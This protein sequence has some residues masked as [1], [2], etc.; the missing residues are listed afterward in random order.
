MSEIPKDLAEAMSWDFSKVRDLIIDLNLNRDEALKDIC[1]FLR[2]KY[3]KEDKGI[4]VGR[5][6]AAPLS[7][8]ML[9]FNDK[10]GHA[11]VR[12]RTNIRR[13]F[14]EDND[15]VP[16]SLKLKDD[17]VTKII[18]RVRPFPSK[19]TPLRPCSGHSEK[20][21]TLVCMALLTMI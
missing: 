6:I 12:L 19:Y 15:G 20:F 18:I 10:E 21:R 4:V 16:I 7:K 13:G 1:D 11:F 5:E 3:M 2:Q 17:G 8:K 9:F 14:I